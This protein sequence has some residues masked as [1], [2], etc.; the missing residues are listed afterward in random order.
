[1]NF[2]VK[3]ILLPKQGGEAV[4]VTKKRLITCIIIF[5]V[6]IFMTKLWAMIGFLPAITWI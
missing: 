2:N 4:T 3:I 1:M 5:L 6:I